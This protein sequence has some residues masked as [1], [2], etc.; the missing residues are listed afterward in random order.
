MTASAT[1]LRCGSELE[2]GSCRECSWLDPLTSIDPRLTPGPRTRDFMAELAE[3]AC[4]E[5]CSSAPG[6]LCAPCLAR[7]LLEGLEG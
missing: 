2:S 7:L 1:C 5:G 4:R 3:E 6:K